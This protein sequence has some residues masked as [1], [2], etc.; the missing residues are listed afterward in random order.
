VA[1][2]AVLSDDALSVTVPILEEIASYEPEE[3]RT[4]FE[5]NGFV[6]QEWDK[7]RTDWLTIRDA[8]VDATGVVQAVA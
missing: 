5:R 2:R 6:I 1:K 4:L 8:G 7:V 3:I